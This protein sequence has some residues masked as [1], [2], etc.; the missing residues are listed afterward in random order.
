MR[1]YVSNKVVCL[2]L[3]IAKHPMMF[4]LRQGAVL[5]V[6]YLKLIAHWG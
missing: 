5:T 1:L 2:L 4:F 6:R 3:L